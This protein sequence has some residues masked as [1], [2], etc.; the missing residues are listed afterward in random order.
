MNYK[1]KD[2]LK[3]AFFRRKKS[4]SE[5]IKSKLP[6]YIPVNDPKERTSFI[7]VDDANEIKKRLTGTIGALVGTNSIKGQINRSIKKFPILISDDIDPDTAV[8]LKQVLEEQYAEFL[9]LLISN[10]VVDVNELKTA[11]GGDDKI[12]IQSIDKFHT[13]SPLTTKS[14]IGQL[15]NKMA[16]TGEISRHDYLD[17]LG[18]VFKIFRESVEYKNELFDNI[19]TES[20]NETNEF[21]KT[22]LEDAIIVKSDEELQAVRKAIIEEA[23]KIADEQ[24]EEIINENNRFSGVSSYLDIDKSRDISSTL[25]NKYQYKKVLDKK[26][27]D[28]EGKINSLN[29]KITDITDSLN[30]ISKNYNMGYDNVIIAEYISNLK[31]FLTAFDFSVYTYAHSKQTNVTVKSSVFTN[32]KLANVANK[33]WDD[34]NNW[35][36]NKSLD[37]EYHHNDIMIKVDNAINFVSANINNI[38]SQNPGTLTTQ[39][40]NSNISNMIYHKKIMNKKYTELLNFRSNNKVKQIGSDAKLSLQKMWQKDLKRLLKDKDEL[41]SELKELTKEKN[42]VEQE[43]LKLEKINSEYQKDKSLFY[44]VQD[45]LTHPIVENDFKKASSLLI[46]GVIRPEDYITYVTKV[47]GI[48]IPVEERLKIIKKF[49]DP[50]ITQNTINR[51]IVEKQIKQNYL[52]NLPFLKRMIEKIKIKLPGNKT[53]AEIAKR[54]YSYLMSKD[55]ADKPIQAMIAAIGYHQKPNKNDSRPFGFGTMSSQQD[56]DIERLVNTY[57][58]YLFRDFNTDQKDLYEL[59]KRLTEEIHYY[60]ELENQQE[61]LNENIFRRNRGLPN[62]DAFSPRF[63]TK[64]F[65]KTDNPDKLLTVPAYTARSAVAYGDARVNRRDQ[66]DRRFHQPL[67][68]EVKFKERFDDGSFSD[69]EMTAV[70]GIL[71]SIKRIPSEEMKYILVS[72]ATNKSIPSIVKNLMSNTGEENFFSK[73]ISSFKDEIKNLPRSHELWRS[74]NSISK[75]AITSKIQGVDGPIPNAHLI[76]SIKE[77]DEVKHEHGIDYL[78]EPKYAAKLMKRYAAFTIMVANDIQERVYIFDDEENS[79]WNVVSYRTFRSTGNDSRGAL[80]DL[81]KALKN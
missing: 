61:T 47:L 2:I 29:K 51:Q 20:E 49:G 44:L 7:A 80:E 26:I 39:K 33:L 64:S 50:N 11:Y 62:P 37:P 77:I 65:I 41:V 25:D 58:D 81:L 1:D 17:T 48:P 71:G 38:L 75:M 19:L 78:A 4:P 67:I 12:A 43:I 32:A 3:E 54:K 57:Q 22:L 9:S 36:N 18:D 14:K 45:R 34:I 60:E 68:I 56:D 21:L 76:F 40:L 8:M 70:I 27:E 35:I 59:K 46:S 52:K 79:D 69:N 31:S 10:E 73:I 6:E 13:N 30:N 74:L 55:K 72:N 42:K 24:Q 15:G 16:R 5:K 28:I 63:K 66:K 23:E 53:S